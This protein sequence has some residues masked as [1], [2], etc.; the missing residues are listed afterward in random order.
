VRFKKPLWLDLGGIAKGYAV[1]AAMRAAGPPRGTSLSINAG[2]DLR[3]TGPLSAEARLAIAGR[4]GNT[5]PRFELSNGALASSQ[6]FPARRRHAGE[7]KSPHLHGHT[8]RN[9]SLTRFVTVVAARCAVADAL[10]KVVL[11]RGRGAAPLLRRFRAYAL[12]HDSA[13]GWRRVGVRA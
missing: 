5:A 1:D 10:T 8:H 7:W 2:G 4:G 9:L 3:I 11:A 12:M 6:G 13:R